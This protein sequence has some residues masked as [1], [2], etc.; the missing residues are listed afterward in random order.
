LVFFAMSRR[1]FESYASLKSK[2]S[3]LW[4][5]AGVLSEQELAALRSQGT[6]V[7]DF[8]YSLE[9]EDREGIECAVETIR[10]HHPG[11][12]VWVGL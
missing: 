11:H 4:V 5:S 8:D 7:S 2:D 10:E 3:P 6:N 12:V 9:I 1:G